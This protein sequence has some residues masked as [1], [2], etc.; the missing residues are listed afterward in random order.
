M[1]SQ[2]RSP[3][4]HLKLASAKHPLS[5]GAPTADLR[6]PVVATLTKERNAIGSHGGSY[7]L[8]RALGVA[9]R[10]L[11]PH[12]RPD[13]SDTEPTV[14]IRP[15][16]A[17]ENKTQIV[18]FDPWGAE[19]FAPL[20]ARGYDIRPTIAITQAHINLPEI[21]AA[22]ASGVLTVD[23]AIVKAAGDLYVTKIAID[24][25][26]YLPGIAKRLG[27]DELTL[28]RTIHEQTGGMF[29]DLTGRRDLK[30]FLPP[31]GNSTVYVFGDVNKIADETTKIAVRVHDECNGSDVFGS[32]ICTCRPYLVQGIQ[33]AVEMA[34]AGGVGI[35]VYLRKEGRALG[36]VT[37]F[38][39]YNARKRKGDRA[40]TYFER[41]ECVAGVQDL[42]F[43]ILMPDILHWLGV[44]Q[45]DRL[46]SMS[47]MKY[48]AI[49]GAGIRVIDRIAFPEDLIPADAQV[50]MAAKKAAGY[51]SGAIAETV[52]LSVEGRSLG[53]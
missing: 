33:E 38:L 46:V 19:Q 8:Y 18:S 13:L 22:I 37:K 6:G 35:V 1:V 17:W 45:I 48:D 50:E 5:W 16:P 34:Q 44:R 32:D 29:A 52:D 2:P 42:R 36:E 28:R 15:N 25:V 20:L 49:V 24:P 40:E 39:V 11:D 26:W 47:D 43:Q 9:S 31:I 30:V 10:Q 27:V 3:K 12:H 4:N 51:Y 21:Q 41:T 7:S 53:E 14:A 23:G